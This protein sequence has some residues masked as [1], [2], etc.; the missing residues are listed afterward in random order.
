MHG[1]GVC[2]CACVVRACMCVVCVLCARAHA[3]AGVCAC[4]CVRACVCVCVCVCAC[5]LVVRAS[6]PKKACALQRAGKSAAL[7]AKRSQGVRR[8]RAH[9]SA[10]PTTGGAVHDRPFRLFTSYIYSLCIRF[11]RLLEPQ[12]CAVRRR[13]SLRFPA[14]RAVCKVRYDNTDRGSCG[15]SLGAAHTRVVAHDRRQ[16]A[17]ARVPTPARRAVPSS[18]RRPRW[19][20]YPRRLTIRSTRGAGE[21]RCR[22]P[23]TLGAAPGSRGC[24]VCVAASPLRALDRR[25]L[26]STSRPQHPGSPRRSRTTWCALLARLG[27]RRDRA[28]PAARARSTSPRLDAHLAPPLPH[29]PTHPSHPPPTQPTPSPPNPPT[30]PITHP[31]PD[32]TSTRAS[33]DSTPPTSRLHTSPA[34]SDSSA[35]SRASGSAR[36]WRT[37]GWGGCTSC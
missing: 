30:H 37:R 34:P 15:L 6:V 33:L 3:R 36:A 14:V 9:P 24:V 10:A 1:A 23:G 22:C 5:V 13:A 16:V 4:A 2:V 32:R 11:P 35:S 29:P 20:P 25:R 8:R 19:T 21:R 26:P 7:R 31:N 12:A 18:R 27:A 28:H 17:R